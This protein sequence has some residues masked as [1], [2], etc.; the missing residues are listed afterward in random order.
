MTSS[1]QTR[2]SRHRGRPALATVDRKRARNLSI[3]DAAWKNLETQLHSLPVKTASELIEKIGLGEIQL[4]PTPTSPIGDI[5]ICRRLQALI[6]NPIAVFSSILAFVRRLCG[7]IH[8]EPTAERIYTVTL[9]ASTIVFY[10][11][12]THPDVLINNSSALIK[13]L[14]Y[15]ILQVE[16]TR[17]PPPKAPPAHSTPNVS[18]AE[19]IFQKINHALA[20]LE[21]AARSPEYKA[22]KMKT[23][24]GLTIKQISRIFKLQKHEVSKVEVSRMIKKGLV[25][26]RELFYDGAEDIPQSSDAPTP[27]QGVQT[28]AYRYL[29]LALQKTLTQPDLE[30][31][32]EILLATSH[33]PYLDFW[34]NEIDYCLREQS[35]PAKQGSAKPIEP[36]TPIR[37]QLA[38]HLEDHFHQKKI[39]REL[40]FCQTAQQ[41]QEVLDRY[42]TKEAG[43]K[44]P[45]KRL[46]AP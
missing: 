7:Q 40:A 43:A 38:R 25:N 39:D 6:E 20:R 46:I 41:I 3:S 10:T 24:D 11:G 9:K 1:E 4:T 29:Q 42:A 45:I 17:Q 28:T 26:F 33:D 18:E 16:A 30:E 44:L 22:L 23:I 12:Y 8:L 37:D 13:W 31:L 14:C 35:L 19:P 27:K 21:T 32:Q 34:L 36:D 15:E 5:P 2:T